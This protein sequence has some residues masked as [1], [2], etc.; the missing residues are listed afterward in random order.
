MGTENLSVLAIGLQI[1]RSCT[2]R[3]VHQDLCLPTLGPNLED[4]IPNFKS[5]PRGMTLVLNH[6]HILH[7]RCIKSHGR[8][9]S[10]NISTV[11]SLHYDF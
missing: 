11:L 4:K 8:E 1:K 10:P 9:L 6:E 2:E 3:I 5:I 7:M